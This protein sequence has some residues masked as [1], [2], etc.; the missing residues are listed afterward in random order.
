MSNGVKERKACSLLASFSSS[1]SS[2]SY[3]TF[4]VAPPV[5]SLS[6]FPSV[7]LFH[8]VSLRRSLRRAR[9][10]LEGLTAWR[11]QKHV[12]RQGC[13]VFPWLECNQTPLHIAACHTHTHTYNINTIRTNTHQSLWSMADLTFNLLQPPEEQLWLKVF[14]DFLLSEIWRRFQCDRTALVPPVV[15]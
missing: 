6:H 11:S 9:T 5:H 12:D 2:H 3:F 14:S 4:S 1:S 13:E 8:S 15:S 7:P 10:A